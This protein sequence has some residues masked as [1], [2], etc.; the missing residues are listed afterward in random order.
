M[1]KERALTAIKKLEKHNREYYAGFLGILNMDEKIALYVN[2]RCMKIYHDYLALYVGG[3]ITAD[4]NPEEEWEETGIKAE[5]LKSI[6]AQLN[7]N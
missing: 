5:T 7:H 1:P 4:S 6:I 3:G 2:L